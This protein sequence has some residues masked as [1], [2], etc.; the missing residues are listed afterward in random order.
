MYVHKWW[1]INSFASVA[2][3]RLQLGLTAILAASFNGHLTVVQTLVEQYGGDM[4]HR[5][6]VKCCDKWL[7][8]YMPFWHGNLEKPNKRGIFI[9]PNRV[10]PKISKDAGDQIF[11]ALIALGVRSITS[12]FEDQSMFEFVHIVQSRMDSMLLMRILLA[13]I[14]LLLSTL[15]PEWRA[16]SLTLVTTDTQP[17]TGQ[18]KWASCP[19]W[20]TLW[21][22]VDLMWRPLTRFACVIYG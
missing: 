16:T 2:C 18:P 22:L 10:H 20:S 6:R 9:I 7:L 11:S 3:L 8:M 1:G 12:K 21:D 14:L 13:A 15:P 17:C 4:L 5:K 19:W